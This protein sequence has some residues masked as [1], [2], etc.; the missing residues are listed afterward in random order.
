MIPQKILKS[1]VAIGRPDATRKQKG[2]LVSIPAFCKLRITRHT[3][4]M[5]LCD[6]FT[7]ALATQQPPAKSW[8][9]AYRRAK[10]ALWKINY[11]CPDQR[12]FWLVQVIVRSHHLCELLDT[13]L[14]GLHCH[15]S[16]RKVSGW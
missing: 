16:P 10:A 4:F 8:W 9:G 6:F 5:R 1:I 11:S 13:Q 7:N 14:D 12:S 2:A 15:H 3:F